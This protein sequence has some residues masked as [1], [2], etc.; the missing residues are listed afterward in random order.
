MHF[1]LINI[2]HVMNLE[3]KLLLKNK[4]FFLKI[5][6]LPVTSIKYLIISYIDEIFLIF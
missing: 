4:K 2:F 6:I 5:N 3:P 1:F